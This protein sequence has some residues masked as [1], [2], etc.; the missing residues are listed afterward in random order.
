[1]LPVPPPH[2]QTG[3][4]LGG[5]SDAES[6]GNVQRRSDGNSVGRM[7]T[8]VGQRSQLMAARF[9]QISSSLLPTGLKEAMIC[10]LGGLAGCEKSLLMFV[11]FCYFVIF[12][13]DFLARYGQLRM[14]EGSRPSRSLRSRSLGPRLM[15][16]DG[17]RY[18][19]YQMDVLF[20]KFQIPTIQVFGAQILIGAIS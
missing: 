19:F 7:M 5:D 20:F 8:D 16:R 6:A 15:I 11:Y 13:S 1:M 14:L 10:V 12:H 9:G 18:R 17:D 3:N 4:R 2:I